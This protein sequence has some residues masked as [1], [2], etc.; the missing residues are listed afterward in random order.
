MELADVANNIV[1]LSYTFGEILSVVALIYFILAI[2]LASI[3][4]WHSTPHLVLWIPRRIT[5]LFRRL[6]S[7]SESDSHGHGGHDAAHGD[8][9]HGH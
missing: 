3:V 9:G 5:R 6:F 2:P 7:H 1:P 8:H 4:I